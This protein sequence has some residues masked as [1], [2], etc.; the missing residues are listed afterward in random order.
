M[1]KCG[2]CS[3]VLNSRSDRD[4]HVRI[5]HKQSIE[6][7]GVVYNRDKKTSAFSCLKCG[8]MFEDPKNLKEHV[9]KTTCGK[10][11]N[12]NASEKE[13][14]RIEGKYD[15]NNGHFMDSISGLSDTGPSGTFISSHVRTRG[16]S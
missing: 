2:I 9:K 14:S 12:K 16:A 1:I 13:S 4:R 7:E 10:S 6:V 11:Q 8:S 15:K 5:Q 3:L